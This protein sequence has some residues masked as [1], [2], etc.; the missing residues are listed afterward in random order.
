MSTPMS[1]L[2][3]VPSAS[4]AEHGVGGQ[5]LGELGNDL[6]ARQVFDRGRAQR[7][8]RNV[9]VEAHGSP[10]GEP[11]RWYLSKDMRPIIIGA[12]R[13]SR[14]E[15]L[16]EEI[17]KTLVPVMGRPMLDWVLEALAAAGFSAKT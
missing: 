1:P 12:G 17:P 16:T 9:G 7:L 15:H 2:H 4:N 13:G 8:L 10:S 6:V 3:R 11:Q 5:V 14:L